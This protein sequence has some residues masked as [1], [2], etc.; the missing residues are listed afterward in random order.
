M[1]TYIC[2]LRYLA[3]NSA[4]MFS[5]SK[6]LNFDKSS[7]SPLPILIV[8]LS[9]LNTHKYIDINEY[10]PKLKL[11]QLQ[12]SFYFKNEDFKRLFNN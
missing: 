3:L 1:L 10:I 5:S 7:T 9:H 2:P 4:I 12:T 6:K 8:L 11:L